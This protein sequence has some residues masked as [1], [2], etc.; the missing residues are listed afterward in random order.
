MLPQQGAPPP[1]NHRPPHNRPQCAPGRGNAGV[2]SLMNTN[3]PPP[4]PPG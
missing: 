4:D 1:R 3:I 2:R